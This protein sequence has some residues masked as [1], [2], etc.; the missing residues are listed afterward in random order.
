MLILYHKQGY[1][2][3][4][5]DLPPCYK[6]CIKL[7]LSQLQILQIELSEDTQQTVE[8]IQAAQ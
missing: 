1:C 6:I 8:D 3:I 5:L 2:I 4:N 7:G